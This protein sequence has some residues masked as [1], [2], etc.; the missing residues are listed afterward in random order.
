MRKE[1]AVLISECLECRDNDALE[2]VILRQA[3]ACLVLGN[4]HL[5]ALSFHPLACLCNLQPCLRRKVA[6]LHCAGELD[7]ARRSMP[8]LSASACRAA[9]SA[10]SMSASSSSLN[11]AA[12]T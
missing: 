12:C 10:A 6:V 11:T 7:H 4:F 1:S 8:K 3:S 2:F 5:K 9:Y